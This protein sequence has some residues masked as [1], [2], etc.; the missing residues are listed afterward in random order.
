[1]NKVKI[2]VIKTAHEQDLIDAYG[3]AG[4]PPCDC[5]KEGMVFYSS[6][7]NKPEGFCEDAWISIHKYVAVLT[8]GVQKLWPGWMREDGT[9]LLCCNDAFRPVTFLLEAV[10]E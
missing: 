3:V 10:E 1:M 5:M 4:M 7:A 8:F 6:F 9:A 2:T